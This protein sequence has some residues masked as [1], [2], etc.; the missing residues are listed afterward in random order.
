MAGKSA[1][2][3][4]VRHCGDVAAIDCPFGHVERIVTGGEG[5]VANV[6]VV[7][8]TEGRP[9]HHRGYNEVYYFL[10]GTGTV[11]LGGTVSS[12]KPGTV[13]VIPAG[14]THSLESDEGG[15]LEFVIFGT[16]PSSMAD[17]R[18]KPRVSGS[19]EPEA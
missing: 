19:E 4:L 9:H 11:T 16:P 12:V 5:D 6:H 1:T 17:E 8:V 2:G 14:V 3:S 7:T 18:A 10:A 15:E 13:V